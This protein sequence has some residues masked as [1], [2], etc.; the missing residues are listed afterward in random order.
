MNTPTQTP[1]ETQMR[2]QLKRLFDG[3]GQNCAVR[4]DRRLECGPG[5]SADPED[6]FYATVDGPLIH[7]FGFASTVSTAVTKALM[8][9][10]ALAKQTEA[11]K[12]AKA[13]ELES[14]AQKIGFKLVPV[15][16]GQ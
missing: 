8:D 10:E 16:E 11:I 15:K 2:E 13:K 4:I 9:Y 12:A 14:Q 5:A 7:A 3:T 1:L 6:E